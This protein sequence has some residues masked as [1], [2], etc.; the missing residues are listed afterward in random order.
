MHMYRII[1]WHLNIVLF[2]H[3]CI[4]TRHCLRLYID[5]TNGN[6]ITTYHDLKVKLISF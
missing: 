6:D 4:H 2:L 3:A 5:G 1:L